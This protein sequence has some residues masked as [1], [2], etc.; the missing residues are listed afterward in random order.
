MLSCPTCSSKSIDDHGETLFQCKACC[1]IYQHPPDVTADYGAGYLKTYD[2]YPTDTI[3][4]LRLG[5]LK[6]FVGKGSL[7][8][9]GYG[10][11]D[12]VRAAIRGGFDAFGSDVHG[13]PCGVREVDLATDEREW[14]VV[15][16]FDSLEHFPDFAMVC[17]PLS[18]AK[19]ALISLPSTPADFPMNRNW[20][21][22]KPGEHLHYF[23]VPSLCH[24]VG[25]KL[26]CTSNLE[27]T[28]R[29]SLNNSQNILTV[30][31]GPNA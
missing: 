17:N 8:D 13:V 27:D 7:L 10:K 20:R 3:S 24:L 12:F 25:K 6:A 26:L 23:S 14:D 5:F 2:Q 15:T 4:H 30:I 31:F 19:Y 29:G 1:H 9:I 22:Y 16:F 28:V 21:H 11:G 18:R